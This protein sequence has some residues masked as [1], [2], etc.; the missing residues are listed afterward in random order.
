[1]YVTGTGK[2]RAGSTD[3]PWQTSEGYMC[4]RSPDMAKMDPNAAHLG[5]YAEN[6]KHTQQLAVGR[7]T[8]S[9]WV[10][11]EFSA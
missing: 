6:S 4:L 10:C 7:P 8:A 11:L 3:F 5:N 9:C 1:M 2:H